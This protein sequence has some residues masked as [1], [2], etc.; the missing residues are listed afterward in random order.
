[1]L[2]KR[3]R[4]TLEQNDEGR[5]HTAIHVGMGIRT[6]TSQEAR[7]KRALVRRLQIPEFRHDQRCI[8][9]TS[10]CVDDCLDTL[11]G[12]EWYS[13]LDANSAYWQ[14]KLAEKDRRKTAFTTKYGLFEFVRMGFGLCNAPA[15]FARVMNLVLHGLNWNIALAFLDDILVLGKCFMDHLRN[16]E[17]IFQRFRTFKLKLKPKKCVFFQTQTEFLGRLVSKDGIEVGQEATRVV[18]EWPRPKNT[19]DVERFAG[20][21]NYH[22]TFIKDYAKLAEPLY[23]VTGKKKFV[24]GDQQ[25]QAFQDVKTALSSAPVMALPNDHDPFILD[26]DASDYAIGAELIQIQGGQE[27]VIS[28]GSFSLTPEQRRYCTTRKELLAVIRFTRLFRHY[29]LGRQFTIRTDHS[30]LMWLLKFKEPQE[31]R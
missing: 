2:C 22:R 6:G 5:C 10:C 26:T 23:R 11:A 13:K 20:L 3:R 17:N 14:V 18:E 16:L 29:L 12:N 7:W 30:S 9:T 24:W 25:E 15:T 19:K 28:Y 4:S 27:R 1:M 8:S 21:A 31:A